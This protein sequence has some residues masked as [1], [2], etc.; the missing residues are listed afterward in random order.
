MTTSRRD[1]TGASIAVAL[2]GGWILSVG[3]LLV[4]VDPARHPVASLLLVPLL[5]WL[6][7]GLF[8]T[9]HDAMHGTVT[10]GSPRL[11][12][13]L[14]RIAAGLY[15][16]F[17]FDALLAA[18][19]RHHDTPAADGDPDYHDGAHPGFFDWY[20][21]FMRTYLTWRQVLIMAVAYNLLAHAL[22]VP[23]P[24]LIC[25]WVVPVLLSTLQ[26]FAFGTWLPHRGEHADGDRLRARSSDLPRWASLLA[27]FHFD[28][29]R[30]HHAS[31]HVPWWRLPVE[32]RRATPEAP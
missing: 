6:S 30:E 21:H 19:R 27:C 14:G 13:A 28:Y 1:L 22:H 17:G 29:H 2:I 5:T 20:L 18:H 24:A 3:T 16:A 9:A 23:E 8:I 11:N 10:P 7:T 25:F 15:A 4:A 32:R 12:R 26:L 31:P